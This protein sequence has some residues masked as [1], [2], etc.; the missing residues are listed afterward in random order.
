[1]EYFNKKRPIYAGIISFVAFIVLSLIIHKGQDILYW[2]GM[3]AIMAAAVATVSLRI[4]IQDAKNRQEYE[5][6]K[7]KEKLE[8]IEKTNT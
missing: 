7:A 4:A 8:N 6:L 5:E 1:M 2:V 3:S